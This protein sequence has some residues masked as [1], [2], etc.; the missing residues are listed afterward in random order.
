MKYFTYSL[1]AAAN[2][3]IDQT[4]EQAAASEK[5]FWSTAERYNRELDTLKPRVSQKAWEFFRYGFGRYG[6]HDASLLS[7]CTGDGVE[8]SRGYLEAEPRDLKNPTA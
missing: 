6:L 4:E 2:D 7:L 5:L 3:W 1:V 8:F